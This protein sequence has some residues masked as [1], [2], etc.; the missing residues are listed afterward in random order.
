MAQKNCLRIMFLDSSFEN[1]GDLGGAEESLRLLVQG[2]DRDK[3][4]PMICGAAPLDR[5]S[6]YQLGKTGTFHRYGH[7]WIAGPLKTIANQKG[8]GLLT[9]YAMSWRLPDILKKSNAQIVHINLLHKWDRFDIRAAR[10]AGCRVVGHLRSLSH[11]VQL[12]FDDVRELD[13]V[14]AVSHAVCDQVV[15]MGC[16]KKLRVIY[17]PVELPDKDRTELTA[18]DARRQM[19][20]DDIGADEL[21]LMSVAALQRTKGH[22]T[23]ISALAILRQSGIKARLYIVGGAFSGGDEEETTYLRSVA[24]SENVAD[25]VTFLGRRDDISRVYAAADIVLALSSDGEAFGR[26]PQEAAIVGRPVIATALGAT[27]ELVIDKQTG[28]LVSAY[29]ADGVARAAQR[30]AKDSQFRSRLVKKARARAVQEFSV[31]THVR[32]MEDLYRALLS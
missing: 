3:I 17:D 28:L 31:E 24:Q 22:D 27:P 7:R 11:R 16:G 15:N 20:L 14:I 30:L 19:G 21:V 9:K 6:Y 8:G 25:F 1:S 18:E 2:F 12:G 4:H 10:L 29:D 26:V 23:A 13:A 5:L 32:Q